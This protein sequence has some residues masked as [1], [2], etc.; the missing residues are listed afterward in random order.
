M[1]ETVIREGNEIERLR[2][3]LKDTSDQLNI[4][5][6]SMPGGVMTYDADT[7]KI[8]YVNEGLLNIFG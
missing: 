4:L 2:R 3:R 1:S 5:L 7:G 6:S 8:L